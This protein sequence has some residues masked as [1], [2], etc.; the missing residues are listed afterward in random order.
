[1]NACSAT[2]AGLYLIKRKAFV[3]SSSPKYIR[4]LGYK[5]LRLNS[6]RRNVRIELPKVM[7]PSSSGSIQSLMALQ[8]SSGQKDESNTGLLD[9]CLFPTSTI[10]CG[11]RCR[12]GMNKVRSL[13]NSIVFPRFES[14]IIVFQNSS[15]SFSTDLWFPYL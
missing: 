15:S 9:L 12:C 14:L 3:I 13:S 2:I 7:S 8:N 10:P 11:V 1:M 5:I 4:M 6:T